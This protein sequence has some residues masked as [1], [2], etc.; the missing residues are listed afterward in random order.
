[1]AKEATAEREVV[2]GLMVVAVEA[3]VE[4]VA[5][6][7]AGRVAGR[8]VAEKVAARAAVGKTAVETAAW[9]EMAARAVVEEIPLRSR[10]PKC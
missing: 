2:V 10:W 9:V 8:E 7:V 3:R 4:R 6:R 5:E 1:M